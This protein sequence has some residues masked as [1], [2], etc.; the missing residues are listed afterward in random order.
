MR[1][2]RGDHR[3][4]CFAFN[5][6]HCAVCVRVESGVWRLE[7]SSRLACSVAK[8]Q[9]LRTLTTA[10]RTILARRLAFRVV[11]VCVRVLV[12]LA[13]LS[14][15]ACDTIVIIITIIIIVDFN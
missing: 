6:I 15:L 12:Q 3:R 8:H 7:S 2:T 4:T 10:V 5:L 9:L 11:C 1:N 13:A 14:W